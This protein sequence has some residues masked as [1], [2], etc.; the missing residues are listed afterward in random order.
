M[1]VENNMTHFQGLFNL[2]K[3][4][5]FSELQ[6]SANF[7]QTLCYYLL[8]QDRNQF[9]FFTFQ[10]VSCGSCQP[11]LRGGDVVASLNKLFLTAM[12]FKTCNKEFI[13]NQHIGNF[14]MEIMNVMIKK[15][16]P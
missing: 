8:L 9:F 4:I 2:K 16:F 15:F 3:S 13:K 14:Q 6:I 10:S 11:R 5:H 1:E 12:S 7:R